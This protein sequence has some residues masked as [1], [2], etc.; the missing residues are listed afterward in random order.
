[1]IIPQFN[2]ITHLVPVDS[3][4]NEGEL[5]HNSMKSD[6]LQICSGHIWKD[7]CAKPGSNQWGENEAKVACYQIGMVWK[8]GSGIVVVLI[9]LIKMFILYSDIKLNNTGSLSGIVYS[10]TFSCSGL[11]E[12]LMNCSVDDYID[13]CYYHEHNS[14]QFYYATA[15]C[16]EGILYYQSILCKYIFYSLSV[17]Y[18]WK[19][20]I[21]RQNFENLC[22]WSM[23]HTL[24]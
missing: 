12:K 16:V 19:S 23:A 15:K 17:L 20:V 7:I 18:I 2:L 14:N 22:I 1:M 5:R 10:K 9:F 24:W 13:T 21:S 8:E 3:S 11:E 4:C 6:I